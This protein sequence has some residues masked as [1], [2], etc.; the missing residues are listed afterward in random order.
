MNMKT[1]SILFAMLLSA[2]AWS[3]NSP[4]DIQ[5]YTI[6]HVASGVGSVLPGTDN[7]CGS[8]NPLDESGIGWGEIVN[9]GA[10]IWQIVEANKPVVTVKTPVAYALPR[11]L[12]CW[13]DLEHWQTPRIETYEMVYKNGFH[14]DVVK[15]R[16]RLQYTYGGGHGAVG[17]YL[18]NVTV[19][20]AELNVLWGYTFDANVEVE[21]AINLGSSADPLAGLELN[22]KW[23]V[24]TVVKES[25]NSMH[26]FVQG[27]GAVQTAN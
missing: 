16:F 1:V 2:P 4:W 10:K 23:T 17:R 25:Q 26:F 15:F 13:A 11:G 14:M 21:R 18:A 6:R 12:N 19:M 7:D 22:M 3:A 8:L 9:I 20:P 5:S 27:D 24:K